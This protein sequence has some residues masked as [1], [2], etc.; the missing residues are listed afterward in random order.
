MKQRVLVLLVFLLSIFALVGCND[1]TTTTT[2]TNATTIITERLPAPTGL[3][4]TGTVLTWNAVTGATGYAIY[5]NDAFQANVTTTSFDF[6][7]VSGNQLL[8]RVVAKAATTGTFVDSVQSAS[9]AYV[10]NATAEIDAINQLMIGFMDGAPEGFAAELVNKGMTATEFATFKTAVET[11][12]ET[13]PEDGNLTAGN[14]ALTVLLQTDTNIEA[15]IS[16]MMIGVSAQLE[17]QILD[18]EEEIDACQ[19]IIN[20]DGSDF[21]C[22]RPISSVEG[23]LATVQVMLDLIDAEKEQ[24][25]LVAT[26]AANYFIDL[27]THI[28]NTL[29]VN[30]QS[31]MESEGELTASEIIVL[32]NEVVQMLLD[33]MPPTADTTLLFQLLASMITSMTDSATLGDAIN[34]KAGQFAALSTASLELYLNFLQDLDAAFVDE[35]LTLQENFTNETMFQTEMTILLLVEFD[36]FETA[37]QPLF[38]AVDN[39]LS[40]ADELALFTAWKASIGDLAAALGAD[41]TGS[42]I[43]TDVFTNLTYPILVAAGTV[44]EKIASATLD[45]MIASDFAL[46]RAQAISES[47]EYDYWDETYTNT[48]T[49][50]SYPTITAYEFAMTNANLDVMKAS[51]NQALAIV[52]ATNTT[53]AAALIALL[54]AVIPQDQLQEMMGI[55]AIQSAALVASINTALTDETADLRTF[56]LALL[57]YLVDQN[58]IEG[59]RTIE[60][61]I[62]NYY[63]TTYG[64]DYADGYFYYDDTYADYAMAIFMA[65]HVDAFFTSNNERL[66]TGF[67]TSAFTVL[68]RTEVLAFLEITLVDMQE[69]EGNINQMITDFLGQAE[70]IKTYD[71]DTLTTEQETIIDD[72]TAIV[73]N[74]PEPE[75]EY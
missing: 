45:H 21:W 10:A 47:F 54:V 56:M 9:I 37:N 12:Q 11:F 30:L 5:V 60:T 32:K 73:E 8:F 35:I 13:L 29:L 63:T 34:E 46:L 41:E 58:V 65:G 59:V 49:G 44:D 15:M 25:V 57:N 40:A 17:Q 50:V 4:I 18:L 53:D 22:Y 43:A 24:M 74:M 61:E 27:Q 66:L 1:T 23:E 72:W 75:T 70:I 20:E 69:M 71:V 14:A 26:N 3:S 67:V 55:N 62:H 48:A 51:I 33:N 19:I 7:S 38:D 31:L 2:T 6:A 39:A 52:E 16:A 28:T 42:S 36:A 68:K 64:A